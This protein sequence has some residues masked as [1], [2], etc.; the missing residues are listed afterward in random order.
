MTQSHEAIPSPSVTLSPDE[1]PFREILAPIHGAV[2]QSGE[3]EEEIQAFLE[4]EIRDARAER[5]TNPTG[6]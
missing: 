1:R 4:Q 6:A 2:R 5:R 3:S